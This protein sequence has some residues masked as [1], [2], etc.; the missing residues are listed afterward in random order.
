MRAWNL[1]I[2]TAPQTRQA[3]MVHMQD[4]TPPRAVSPVLSVT[5]YHFWV[6][7]AVGFHLYSVAFCKIF[8][9]SLFKKSEISLQSPRND[10]VTFYR[11]SN[12]VQFELIKIDHVQINDTVIVFDNNSVI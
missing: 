2:C 6:I 1:L 8:Q 9:F 12:T 10:G 11:N 4:R 7:L 3:V 5:W